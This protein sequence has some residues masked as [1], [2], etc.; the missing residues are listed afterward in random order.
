MSQSDIYKLLYH[1]RMEG[2]EGYYSSRE[3]MGMLK[4]KGILIGIS[5]VGRQAFKLEITDFF[6]SRVSG[7]FKNWERK[8]RLKKEY[9]NGELNV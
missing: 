4:N 8:W 9:C 5:Q 1:K 7:T 6:E 3:I 2:D